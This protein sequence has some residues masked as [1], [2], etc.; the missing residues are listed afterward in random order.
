MN[1]KI[2]DEYDEYVQWRMSGPVLVE[3]SSRITPDHG[4]EKRGW[5]EPF[6][7]NTTQGFERA[8]GMYRRP[9]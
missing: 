8:H 3:L 1:E 2:I 4:C 5:N 6:K 7:A 9:E